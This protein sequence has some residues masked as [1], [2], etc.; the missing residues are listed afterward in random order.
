MASVRGCSALLCLVIN[1]VLLS[2]LLAYSD[3]NSPLH[4]LLVYI[5]LSSLLL[6]VAN[7]LQAGS[8]GCSAPWHALFCESVGFMNQLGSSLMLL[9]TLWLISLIVLRYWCPNERVILTPRLDALVWGSLVSLA[10][11]GASVPIATDSY[12]MDWSW[13]WIK[14]SRQVEQWVLWYAWLLGGLGLSPLLLVAALCYSER[15]MAMYYESSRGINSCRRQST[16]EAV[17]KTK[18]LVCCMCVYTVLVGVGVGLKQ[19]SQVDRVR[20][21]LMI[22]GVLEPMCILAIPVTFVT[23]LYESRQKVPEKPRILPPFSSSLLQRAPR[24]P[25]REKTT[26]GECHILYQSYSGKAVDTPPSCSKKGGGMEGESEVSE[27]T[28]SLLVTQSLSSDTT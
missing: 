15:R 17:R 28:P 16:R 4:R 14:A 7:T 27:M 19:V 18:T 12:G 5:S 13:C 2:T 21:F 10:L 26:S 22:L 6:L 9:V 11:V 23:Q 1:T 3:R 25:P 20:V 8:A 24:A